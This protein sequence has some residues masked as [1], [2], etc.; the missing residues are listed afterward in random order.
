MVG[1]L[2]GLLAFL[3]AFTFG[4][5]ATRFDARRQV[6]LDE[7]NAI[8]TTYLRARLLSEPHG[9]Q[10]RSF[11]RDYV[12][13]RLEGVQTGKVDHAIRRSQE[14]QE[15]LWTQA[16]TVSAKNPGS[17]VVGLFV[18]SLNEVIDLHTKRVMLG[19][20]NRIPGIIWLALYL[21]IIL[22]MV[23]V[24]YQA[25]LAGT[26]RSLVTVGLALTFA[27][28]MLLIADLDRPGEGLLRVSQQAMIDLRNQMQ[29]H[30]P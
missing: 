16:V 6:L 18:Q 5:A 28:V 14:L 22:A 4:M 30:T 24:G 7:V 1:A 9:T 13:V 23:S 21:V 17:Y 20:H 27:V 19:L 10:V 8:G 15:Q 25:G 3:L 11:L 2:L 26:S 12:D 29:S